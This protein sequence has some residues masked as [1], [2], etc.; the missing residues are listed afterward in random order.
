MLFKLNNNIMYLSVE[1]MISHDDWSQCTEGI[2]HKELYAETISSIIFNTKVYALTKIKA[3]NSKLIKNLLLCI[4]KNKNVINYSIL[5]NKNRINNSF[6][7]MYII[8]ELD[9]SMINI[10]YKY[11]IIYYKEYIFNGIEKWH[12]ILSNK[13]L[14]KFTKDLDMM[15]IKVITQRAMPLT[16]DKKLNGDLEL[17]LTEEKLLLLALRGGLFD[18]PRSITYGDLARKIG[19]SKPTL[20]QEI[21]KALWKILN[22]YYYDNFN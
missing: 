10:L 9:G 12:I 20:T 22:N 3:M 19:I 2:N 15:G 8:R 11:N 21:R 1:L 7:L 13:Y 5:L 14:K 18:W 4:D 17:T 6:A 16:E